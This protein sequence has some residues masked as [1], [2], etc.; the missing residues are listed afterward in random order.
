MLML[1]KLP[2]SPHLHNFNV[3]IPEH[4]SLGTRLIFGCTVEA[5]VIVAIL[6]DSYTKYSTILECY[7]YTLN[8]DSITV[9][10]Y[11]KT[12]KLVM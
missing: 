8:I 7:I 1:E 12:N 6:F 2:G 3:C 9:S 10:S 5:I 11:Y 4:G